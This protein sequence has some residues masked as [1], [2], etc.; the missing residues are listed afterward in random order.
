MIL[1]CSPQVS[2]MGRPW[3][4]PD[5]KLEGLE[6]N[7]RRCEGLNIRKM[8]LTGGEGPSQ[9]SAD[10]PVDTRLPNTS[11]FLLLHLPLP[12]PQ[13]LLSLSLFCPD[14]VVQVSKEMFCF[15]LWFE[16]N[17]RNSLYL[18]SFLC[19]FRVGSDL[20]PLSPRTFTPSVALR[21]SQCE[22]E[23]GWGL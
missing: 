17:E 16:E 19:G 20:E 21:S 4:K 11:C 3:P 7:Q 22:R 8:V 12:P 1:L 6:A 2:F 15:F 14:L 9:V 18:H 13:P 10:V 23:K 5:V